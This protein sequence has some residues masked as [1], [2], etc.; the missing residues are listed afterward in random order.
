MNMNEKQT[1]LIVDDE[2]QMVGVISYAF[3]VAGYETL[4][5]YNARQAS[6]HLRNYPIDLVVLDVM[7]PGSSGLD[8]CEQ[9][10]RDSKTPVLMLTAKSDQADM[11]KGLEHGADDYMAKPFSTRELLL[12][13]KAILRRSAH[14]PKIIEIGSLQINLLSHTVTLA[15]KPISL[16]PLQHRLLAYFA[17]NIGRT[18][19]IQE[20]LKQVW[21]LD[22][23]AGGAEMVKVEVYRLRQ[24]IEDNP[25]R[26]T[27]IRTV[28]GVGYQLAAAQNS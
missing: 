6:D 23:Q 2:P 1:I 19:S 13:A 4:I 5:A 22:T 27:V 17:Q 9:I 20:L 10:R 18:L 28:R 26:P 7:L 16:S 15:G 11:I 8:L 12:R 24:K 21:E 3:Q 14:I 25:K